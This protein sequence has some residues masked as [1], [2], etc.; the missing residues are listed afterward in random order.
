MVLG[1]GVA[2]V[3]ATERLGNAGWKCILWKRLPRSAARSAGAIEAPRG[4]LFHR[5]AFDNKGNCLKA[6]LCIPTNQNR[7]NIQEDFEAFVPQILGRPPE[8]IRLLLEM[9]VRS[10]DPC[11]SCATHCLNVTFV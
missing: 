1:A 5:Y 7:A 6:N 10:C 2:G 4:I 9:L 3:T 8:E 11:V